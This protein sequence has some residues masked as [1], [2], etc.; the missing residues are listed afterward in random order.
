MSLKSKQNK[1]IN[2]AAHENSKR[3]LYTLA[4]LD[5]TNLCDRYAE[6]GDSFFPSSPFPSCDVILKEN[7]A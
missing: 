3:Q 7:F 4:F 2:L 6:L 1:T 5:F